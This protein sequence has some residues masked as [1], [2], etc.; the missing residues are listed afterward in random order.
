M[1]FRFRKLIS[2]RNRFRRK[3]KKFIESDSS[4]IDEEF[5]NLTFEEEDNFEEEISS[6]QP[7]KEELIASE[8]QQEELAEEKLEEK[9]EENEI[10]QQKT[11]IEGSSGIA[12]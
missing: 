7:L 10:E 1:R 5:T 9:L 8:I 4:E 3:N 6:N 2:F 12:L 11:E